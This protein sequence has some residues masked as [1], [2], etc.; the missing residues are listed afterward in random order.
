M[1][2]GLITFL[3]LFVSLFSFA[4]NFTG[5][6]KGEF[7]DKS[8]NN[9]NFGGNSC[10]YVIEIE[11][12]G[13]KV[14]GTSYTYFTENGKRYYTICKLEGIIK[15]NQ[16]YIEIKE[17]DRIKTNIPLNIPNCFQIHKL[18]YFKKGNEETLE[19]NWIPAPNQSGNCGFGTTSLSRRTLQ[20][21][22]NN[23]ENKSSVS[24]SMV[25]SDDTKQKIVKKS[26]SKPSSNIDKPALDE[27]ANQDNSI[28]DIP[29]NTE[30]PN[31]NID[32]PT[33]LS[34]L[35]KRKNTVIKTI[36]VESSE[37]KVALYDNGDVDGDSISVFFNGNLILSNKRLSEKAI[38]ITLKIDEQNTY[39][40]LIMY[41]ENLG[42]IP[43][44][45]ALMVV[46]D[47]PNRYEVRITSDLEKS[48]V[49]RFVKKN[50][51]H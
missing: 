10:E 5:Q 7:I 22:Y 45:T 14:T 30:I 15:E 31:I 12:N 19:G 8:T 43:P 20:N 24:K 11:G 23:A 39:N 35:E 47:G 13:S 50:T 2:K 16:K 36:E 41:A 46:N 3:G 6:W 34:K 33:E 42:T 27:N 17:V 1:F 32:L 28:T 44:N 18:T 37:I 51:P 26:K 38:N 9:G 25:T 29:Q 21:V 49:I 4:Q 40:E 48:G